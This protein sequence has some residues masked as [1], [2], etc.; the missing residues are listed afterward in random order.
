MRVIRGA[1]GKT[2]LNSIPEFN[3]HTFFSSTVSDE[4]AAKSTLTL[5]PICI[6]VSLRISLQNFR[7]ENLG[8][9]LGRA[10]ER[11]ASARAGSHAAAGP[12]A[13]TDGAGDACQSGSGDDSDVFV[14]DFFRRTCGHLLPD[15]PARS[16]RF[17][18]LHGDCRCA[19]A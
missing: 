16:G 11:V 5:R 3:L 9:A 2:T 15:N 4:S 10:G 17:E 18:R 14:V 13:F 12:A 1:D 6:D 8:C 19:P 7:H